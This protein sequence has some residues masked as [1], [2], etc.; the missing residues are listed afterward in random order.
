[1]LLPP[2]QHQKLHRC[3]LHKYLTTGTAAASQGTG[4]V[5]GEAPPAASTN[6]P[7]H[8]G[9]TRQPL[10]PSHGVAQHGVCIMPQEGRPEGRADLPQ[11]RRPVHAL[12]THTT[13]L[14]S[15]CPASAV[16]R[17]LT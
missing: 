5:L 14:P 12:P 11:E 9:D 17:F 13:F 6:S 7:V 3:L 15:A 1:M 4:E 2:G 8:T 10:D 16:I